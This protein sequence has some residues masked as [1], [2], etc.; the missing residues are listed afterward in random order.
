MDDLQPQDKA[1][2]EMV[3]NIEFNSACFYRYANV[4]IDQLKTNL[5]GD[6][7]LARRTIEAFL[8]ASKDAIPTGKQNSFAAHNPP[9]FILAVVRKN[10]TPVSLANAFEKP[11]PTGRNNGLA[12]PSIEALDRYWGEFTSM[13]GKNGIKAIAASRM[14]DKPELKNLN[15]V[16]GFKLLT[17]DELVAAV[18]TAG[19]F[20]KEAQS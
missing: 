15:L 4:D 1:G 13:Y 8:R 17:F 16:E 11:V 20:A 10:G 2:A 6:E 14:S 19:G 5:G 9:A 12:E 7:D 18:M 3:G